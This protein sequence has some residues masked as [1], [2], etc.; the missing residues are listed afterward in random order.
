MDK[1]HKTVTTQ[2]FLLVDSPTVPARVCLA[3]DTTKQF[4]HVHA[5]TS[6]LRAEHMVWNIYS[7]LVYCA[8]V[9]PLNG[10]YFG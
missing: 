4:D 8:L 7:F 3:Q 10:W 9:R 5:F 1:I 6:F 2:S